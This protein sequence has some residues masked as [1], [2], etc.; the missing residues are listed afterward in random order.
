MFL[1]FLTFVVSSNKD[2]SL[3][4][5][6]SKIMKNGFL[7]CPDTITYTYYISN[8]II[9]EGVKIYHIF[10]SEVRVEYLIIHC[11][12]QNFSL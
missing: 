8:I 4:E 1:N 7:H 11:I 9:G 12:L 10:H 5:Q 3:F 6:S 2:K